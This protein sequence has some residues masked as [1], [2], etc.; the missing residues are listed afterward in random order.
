MRK[1]LIFCVAVVVF[2]G[3]VPVRGCLKVDLNT[4]ENVTL[5]TLKIEVSIETYYKDG[6][7]C[8]DGID[9]NK[10]TLLSLPDCDYF[11]VKMFVDKNIDFFDEIYAK[12]NNIKPNVDLKIIPID[13]NKNSFILT[14]QCNDSKDA[15]LPG[16][17]G[18][19]AVVPAPGAVLL[20]AIN[21]GLVGWLRRRKTF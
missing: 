18:M 14:S 1:L 6:E 17:Q 4:S 20:S 21:V 5:Y 10:F 16:N 9:G 12:F 19:A 11:C 7:S 2:E 13:G 15:C 3:T 8:V